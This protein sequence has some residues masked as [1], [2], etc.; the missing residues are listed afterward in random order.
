MS[1]ISILE[2]L[3]I[4]PLRILFEYI[5]NLSDSVIN[6]PGLSIIS[7]SLIMNILVLPL[8]KRA[9]D[10][11]EEARNVEKKLHDGVAHIKKTFSG[12]ERMMILQAYYRQ[13][14]YKPTDALKGSVSLLLQIP[15]FMAA[16]NFLSNLADLQGTPLGPI[17]DLGAPDGLIVIGGFAI[18]LLPILMTL[19]NVISSAIYLKGFP[20]KSKIQIY[21]MALFFLVFLYTSPSGL[22]FYWTLNNVFSLGKTIYYKL[23]NPQKVL[24]IFIS[25][26]GIVAIIF[27]LFIYKGSMKM[28]L[29][30]VALGLVMQVALFIPAI[31]KLMKKFVKETTAQPNKKMFLSGSFFLTVLV[32]SLIS[33]TYIA[34]SPQEFV[35]VTYFYNPLWYILST[36]CLS[37]GTFMIWL[38][39]FYWLATP[40]LK[41]LFDRGI[42]VLSGIMIV[43][44]MFFGTKLGNLS[45]SLQYEN[46]MIFALKEK[47]LNIA[48]LIVVAV[49]FYLIAK[50]WSKLVINVL[51]VAAVAISVM[52]VVNVVTIKKSVDAISLEDASA[53]PHFQLDKNGQNVVVIMLDRAMGQYV[54]YILNEKP[55]LKEKFDGFTYYSNTVSFGS[56]TNFA[57]SS[58]V[59]G[60]EYTPVEMNKRDNELLADKHNEALKVMPV[61][62]SENGYDV[63]VCDPSYANYSWIPDLSIYDDYPEI[64]TYITKGKFGDEQQKQHSIDANCRNF[65]CFSLMK[66]MPLVAQPTIYCNGNYRIAYAAGETNYSNQSLFGLS[67][68]KGY[69]RGFMEAYDSLTNLQKLT[70]ISENNKNTFLFIA[71]EM[72]H[73]TNLLQTPNY[74]PAY[75]VDNTQYDAEHKDRFTVNGMTLSMNSSKEMAHYHSNMGALLRIADW[76][77]Y[78]KENDVYD[79]TKIIIVADHGYDFGQ[80]EELAYTDPDFSS[81]TAQGY[82]PLLLVKDFNSKGFTVSDEFMTNA[83]VPTLAFNG[84]IENPVNP[85]TG[86]PINSDEKYAHDQYIIVS[87]EWQVTVNNGNTFL[88]ARWVS[89]SGNIWDKDDWEF[90]NEEIVLKEHNF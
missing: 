15:F 60:Y 66:C 77:D 50:K 43:N 37:V 44:Y 69:G 53:V 61:L 12:D 28:K 30:V 4:G 10:M 64:N 68:A 59:G 49:V 33:S 25:I 40:K 65:F 48:V 9:D 1:I 80:L 57:I 45:P 36:L 63:T 78:L 14:N 41:V 55:E 71:N 81:K 54:P 72:T 86:K 16:Y 23:K 19:V 24:R 7:L 31:T 89:V 58:L 38:R 82:F 13:N 70:T 75:E 74:T 22:V 88:P 51:L 47:I 76:L 84:L 34:S 17:K 26:I 42:W 32:G 52:S 18:N 62:F 85:F 73:D 39:V 20:L 79:N 5:F 56:S 90:C 67:K 2:T 83:D 27:G 11:Q 87:T 3:V 21:G 6:N 8:Y 35:D 46:D 29:L